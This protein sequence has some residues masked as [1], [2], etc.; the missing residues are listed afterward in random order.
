MIIGKG[1]PSEQRRRAL[2]GATMIM[3]VI[4]ATAIEAVT[5]HGAHWR[6][7]DYVKVGAI[8][9]LAFILALRSTTSMRLT[10]RNAELDDELSRANRASAAGW[11]FWALMPLLLALFVANFYWPMSIAETAPI[12]MVAGAAAAGMRFVY[13]ERK[14]SRE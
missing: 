1:D 14:G 4:G 12:L 3:L 13:L 2:I 10:R 11:G 7:V 6:S 5:E 9:L 8:L